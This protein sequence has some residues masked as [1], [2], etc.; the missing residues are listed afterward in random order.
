MIIKRFIFGISLFQLIA[1]IISIFPNWDLKKS[2]VDLLSE[3]NS[4]IIKIPKQY[5]FGGNAQIYKEIK[6]ENNKITVTN[7]LYID[8]QYIK[9]VDWEGIESLI[10][11]KS[12]AKKIKRRFSSK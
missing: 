4:I 8:G 12:S 11:Y 9:N 7:K 3:N 6:K 2:S 1:Q 10:I 5:D